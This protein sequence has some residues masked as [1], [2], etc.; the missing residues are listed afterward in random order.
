M[1]IRPILPQF[2]KKIPDFA[3]VSVKLYPTLKKKAS[4]NLYRVSMNLQPTSKE[5]FSKLPNISKLCTL[6]QKKFIFQK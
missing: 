2:Y 5:K 4:Q 3:H 6:Y 1:P